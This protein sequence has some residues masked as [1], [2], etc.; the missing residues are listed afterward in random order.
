MNDTNNNA[1]EDQIE[2]LL[3]TVKFK[4]F[5]FEMDA[6]RGRHQD[7][8]NAIRI[9]PDGTIV[10]VEEAS[11]CYGEDEYFQRVPHSLTFH[12]STGRNFTPDP[13]TGWSWE[14]SETG[15]YVGDS[16]TANADWATVDLLDTGELKLLLA[17]GWKRFDLD[18]TYWVAEPIT[19]DDLD[20]ETLKSV[21]EWAE[22]GNYRPEASE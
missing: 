19:E 18:L 11:P 20:A 13:H 7:N 15:K 14:E 17:K 10:E 4:Y 2:E 16:R 1:T 8:W 9:H 22:A 6:L 5:N 3:D 12:V 21:R